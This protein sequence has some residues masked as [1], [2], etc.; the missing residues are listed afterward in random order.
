MVYEHNFNETLKTIGIEDS[1]LG[2]GIGQKK[3]GCIVIFK[4]FSFKKNIE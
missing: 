2:L 3:I 4:M 1:E